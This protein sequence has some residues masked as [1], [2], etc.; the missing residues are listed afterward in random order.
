MKRSDLLAGVLV[1]AAV[2]AA[3]A[4]DGAEFSLKFQPSFSRPKGPAPISSRFSTKRF[5]RKQ[6]SHKQFSGLRRRESRTTR[7]R[8]YI[9]TNQ[10]IRSGRIRRYKRPERTPL[11]RN[12]S[13]RIAGRKRTRIRRRVRWSPNR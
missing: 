4:V 5:Q 6:L 9:P 8:N 10:Q 1:G 13:N 12:P 7:F 3:P 2:M 11:S